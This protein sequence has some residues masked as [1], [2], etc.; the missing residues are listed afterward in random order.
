LLRRIALAAAMLLVVALP[1]AASGQT[2]TD[3]AAVLLGAASRFANEGRADVAEALFEMI[4]QRFGDTPAADRVR[5]LRATSPGASRAGR[6]ELMVWSTLYGAWVGVAVPLLLDADGPEPYGLGLLLGAPGGFVLGRMYARS[7][8][9]SEGQARAITFGGTWGT[10]QGFGWAEVFDIGR[11]TERLCP[12]PGLPCYDVEVGDNTAERVGA[13][14][15]GGLTGIAAGALLSRRQIS[16]GLAATVNYGALWGTWFGLA[17]GLLTDLEDDDL[18]AAALIGAN[19]GLLTGA[20]LGPRWR[21]SRNRARLISLAG[22]AGGLAGGGID[23][24]LRIDDEK[25]AI[26]IPLATSVGGLAFGAWATRD[27]D[28]EGADAASGVLFDLRDGRWSV[29]MPV[30]APILQHDRRRGTHPAL[31]VPVLRARF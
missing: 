2:R 30:P 3:S 12:E 14:L 1:D 18:L 28:A 5:Q 4:L 23:L 24:L 22:L 13:A 20:L 8:P 19:A 26:L 29:D 17:T 31:F 7:R 6:T 27:F 9:L 25:T 10:W 15:A 16:N 21:L 11:R